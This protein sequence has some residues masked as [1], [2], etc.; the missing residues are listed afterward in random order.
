VCKEASS[1]RHDVLC[2][3]LAKLAGAAL[4][5]DGFEVVALVC[6]VLSLR[7]LGDAKPR[8]LLEEL[9]AGVGLSRSE[10]RSIAATAKL[11]KRYAAQERGP[12]AAVATVATQD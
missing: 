8:R 7:S 11:V 9:S 2:N 4:D 1:R 5:A 10:E 3:F 12:F 6:A